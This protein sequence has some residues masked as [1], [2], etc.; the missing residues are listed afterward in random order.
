MN[1]FSNYRGGGGV[2]VDL[3]FLGQEEEDIPDGVEMPPPSM[4]D[5]ADFP[6]EEFEDS[7][8]ESD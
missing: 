8:I 7:S 4:G 2:D 5:F 1:G 3:G 6:T